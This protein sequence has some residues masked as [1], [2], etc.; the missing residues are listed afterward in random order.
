VLSRYFVQILEIVRLGKTIFKDNMTIF[1]IGLSVLES[2]SLL[3]AVHSVYRSSPRSFSHF[4]GVG[5]SK[6]TNLS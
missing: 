1:K 3:T 4:F 6:L 2:L 5:G